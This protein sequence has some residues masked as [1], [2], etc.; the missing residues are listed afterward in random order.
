MAKK[1]YFFGGNKSEGNGTM[2]GLL[3]GKGANIDEMANAGLPV[4]PGFTI[5]TEV[6]NYYS[7][8]GQ[9]PEGLKQEVEENLR[10]LEEMQGKKLGD[11]KDPLLVSV[12]S[13]LKFSMP[14]MMDTVL[15]LGMNDVNVEA[16]A[17][18]TNNPKFAYDCY[19]RFIQMYGDVIDNI[20]HDY[21]E[22]ILTEVKEKIT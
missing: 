3:G 11:P 6:C 10:K 15:N 4:P 9:Y 22:E 18:L 14:G 21:F 20:D 19:R 16:F 7:K 5:T 1:V 13:G 8:N 2:K 12:R 17:T